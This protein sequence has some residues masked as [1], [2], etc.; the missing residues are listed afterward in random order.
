M[1]MVPK[2]KIILIAS[3]CLNAVLAAA[4]F[5]NRSNDPVVAQS[6]PDTA[7]TA[8]PAKKTPDNPRVE[9]V[10]VDRERP[11]DWTSVES[12]DYLEYI[13]NLRAVGCPEET[14]RDIIIADVNKLYAS[15]IAALYPAPKDFKFWRVEDRLARNEDRE[16]DAKRRELGEEKRLLIREL[17]GI[18]YDEEL[19]RLS[20]RP[21]EDDLRYGFLSPEKQEQ[22]KALREKYRAMERALFTDGNLT[23]E[24]R[25]K[26]MALRAEGDAALVALLGPADY[27]Q[28]QFRNSS[29]ARNMRE[30]LTGFQPTEEE[31]KQIFQVR[32][33]YDDLYA[34]SRDG[35]DAAADQERKAAQ[36]KLEDQLKSVL[37]VDRFNDYQLSQDGRFRESLD[38]AQRYNLP[39]ETAATVYQVRIASEHERKRIQNDASLTAEART[40]ALAGLSQD[41]RAALGQTLGQDVLA[42]YIPRAGGW[43]NQISSQGN[44]TDRGNRGGDGG[45][46]NGR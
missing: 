27:E 29:T 25:A 23:S 44:S 36:Q 42:N 15:K 26:F 16:R 43:L 6:D 11:M 9:T 21:T 28:Y 39:R 20:G 10:L 46:R 5:A 35:R 38:F 1:K 12:A 22:T 33:A 4:W 3:F 18:D 19:A 24:N 37:G 30:N 13:A 14:V 17:L 41:A 7:T 8:T 31:F 34:S 45:R 32:K 2:T 40:A